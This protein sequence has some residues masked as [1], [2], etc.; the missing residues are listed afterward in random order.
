MAQAG[1]PASDD[2]GAPDASG[3][4]GKAHRFTYE[5]VLR[6]VELGILSEDDHI[7][8]VDGELI[9]VAAQTRPHVR[10]KVW[11]NALLTR[12]LSDDWRVV[13]DSPLF[14]VN[15][16][17]LEPDLYVHPARFSDRDL[18]GRDVALVIEVSLSSL[19]LDLQSKAPIYARL[20]IPEYWVFDV[21]GRRV[22]IHRDP[23]PEGYRSS[24]EASAPEVIVATALPDL[25][26]RL[27][28][29]P[30]SD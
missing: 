29:Q 10:C 13:P 22:V 16:T 8:F 17:R 28:D 3:R 2:V 27:S 23:T 18:H 21:K 4:S 24:R 6:M 1:I 12:G 20:E 26:I 9:D 11:L 19:T 7:E 30:A 15:G 5:D 25:E 14:L